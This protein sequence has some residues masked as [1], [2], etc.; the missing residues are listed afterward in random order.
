MS[1][2]E[3]CREYFG[4]TDLYQ[5]LE[6]RKEASDQEIHRGYRKVSLKVHPDRVSEEEKAQATVK[7]QLLSKAHAILTDKEQRAVYDE[8]GIIDENSDILNQD[9]CWE[10]YWRL[11]FKK[12]TVND[13]ISFEKKY[14]GSEEEVTDV[15]EAYVDFEGDMDR[16]LESVL[17]ANYEDEDRIREIIQKAIDS[18]DLPAY[19]AFTKETAKKRT[20]RKRK[21]KK[22]AEEAEKAKEELGLGDGEDALTSLIKSR[23]TTR[24]QEL[25]QFLSNMEAKYCKPS[26]KKGGKATAKG[27]KKK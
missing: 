4:T 26:K 20:A 10:E 7:F 2:L 11:L 19:D 27:K 13:I 23:Q 15:K 18:G 24:E 25:D 1:V 16:I 14:K 8:Q 21:A 6:V 5:V 17:C 12:L 3:Q 22:E 9:R